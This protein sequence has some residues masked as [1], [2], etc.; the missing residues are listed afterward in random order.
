M[1]PG[2]KKAS[3]AAAVGLNTTKPSPSSLLRED[4]L[5]AKQLQ[6]MCSLVVELQV[7]VT[8][9]TKENKMLR[10]HLIALGVHLDD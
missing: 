7:K 3:W 8:R 4:Y 10:C 6:D 9:L 1:I 5:L 2:E